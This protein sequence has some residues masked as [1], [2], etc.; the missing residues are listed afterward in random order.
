MNELSLNYTQSNINKSSF[1]PWVDFLG[2]KTSAKFH[3]NFLIIVPF[4][5]AVSCNLQRNRCLL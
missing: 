1:F 5:L 4:S 2:A 3:E